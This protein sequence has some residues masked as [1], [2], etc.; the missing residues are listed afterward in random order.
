M[1]AAVT[2]GSGKGLSTLPIP[3]AAKTGTA[4]V[5]GT[6]RTHAW[7]TAFA[8]FEQPKLVLVVLLEQAGGGDRFAVPVARDVLSW[9]FSPDRQRPP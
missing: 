6:E 9:Y 7:V 4:Q 2:D 3:V 5:G 1:R 8:P